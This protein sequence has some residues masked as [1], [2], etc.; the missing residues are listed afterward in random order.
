ME[1]ELYNSLE[2]HKD[3]DPKK[4]Y[5]LEDRYVC[6]NG[7]WDTYTSFFDEK[8]RLWIWFKYLN[9]WKLLKGYRG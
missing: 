8:G 9:K 1:N 6:I 5:L 2:L 4:A 7:A 3:L